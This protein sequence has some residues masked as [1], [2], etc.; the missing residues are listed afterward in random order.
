MIKNPL[1]TL[2]RAVTLWTVSLSLLLAACQP[3]AAPTDAKQIGRA[4][5]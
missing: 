5:V 1:S 4:H 3:G 2:M